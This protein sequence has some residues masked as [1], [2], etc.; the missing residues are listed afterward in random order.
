MRARAQL[1]LRASGRDKQVEAGERSA[2]LLNSPAGDEAS[3]VD[4]REAEALDQV[5]HDP[6]GFFV[7][8]GDEDRAL[9]LALDRPL[10]KT[11][12]TDG[13]ERLD[14]P[15]FWRETGHNLAGADAAEVGKNE[16]GGGLGERVG[17]VDEDTTVPLGQAA[18]GRF[19]VLP[20][21]GEQHVVQT[22]RLLDGRR[23]GAPAEFGHLAGK[24]AGTAST[25]QDNLMSTSK[26]LPRNRKRNLTGSDRPN[27]H[28][29]V[30]SMLRENPLL[31][32]SRGP[33]RVAV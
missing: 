21:H 24:R 8:P 29:S 1:Q 20:R 31:D 14:D 30:L 22:G 19:D 15:C 25:A 7:I 33:W 9:A 18:Q 11:G 28:R 10:V 5:F 12:H 4:G 26:R 6:L 13:V 16:L 32:H 23:R 27:P 3:E 2:R 17:G